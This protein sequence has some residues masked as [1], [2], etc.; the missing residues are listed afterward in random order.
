MEQRNKERERQIKSER[1]GPVGNSER[2]GECK[3]RLKVNMLV[4]RDT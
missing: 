1:D 3:K 2:T 4:K